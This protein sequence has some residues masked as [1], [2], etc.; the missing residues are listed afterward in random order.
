MQLIRGIHNLRPRHSGCV[1]TAGNF[2]GV[3]LG[4]Q[5]VLR[6]LAQQ[7]SASGVPATVIS[8]EPTPN[9]FFAGE[10]APARLMRFRDKFEALAECGMD[11]LLLLRF[12]ARLAA[13]SADAFIRRVLI[14]GLGLRFLVVGDDFRFG[15]GREGRFETL[16]AAGE[17]HGFAVEK[18]ET[19]LLDGNR[20]SS[21]A[22]REALAAGDMHQAARLLGR[23][24]R[25]SGRVIR[26]DGRGQGMGYPTANIAP[27]R[28]VTPVH[29]IFAVRV[30]GGPFAAPLPAVASLGTRPTVGGSRLLLEVHVFDVDADLYGQRLYVDF[31]DRLRDEE[32]FPDVPALIEQMDR[33]AA[34]ARAILAA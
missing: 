6:G 16:R 18:T 22:I 31:V 28:L 14:D 7:A 32:H 11:R 25:M 1:A 24:Y 19:L 2:D 13:L 17:T 9:E 4:H 27:G 8:F 33:D 29:G 34:Q 12:D 5:A 15:R 20:V 3:H 23:P 21:T 10:A 30:S 26:G